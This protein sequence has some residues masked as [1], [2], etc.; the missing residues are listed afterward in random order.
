MDRLNF[1]V[2]CYIRFNKVP[3]MVIICEGYPQVSGRS[4][5]TVGMTSN[6]TPAMNTADW[7][8]RVFALYTEL[9]GLASDSDAG[10]KRAHDHWRRGRDELF[11]SHPASPLTPAAREHFKGLPVADYAPEARLW[12]DVDEE[13]VGEVMDVPTGT[14]GVVRFERLGTVRCGDFG[15]LAL[16][17]HGGYG[18]GLF[19]PVRDGLAGHDGGTYGGGRYLLDTIKGAYLGGNTTNKRLLV[20]FNFAYNPSCAYDEAWACPLPG[21]ANR[22]SAP[23]PFGELT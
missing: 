23:L 13:G 12:A 18:G 6:L 2:R 7:R 1:L 19:L 10:A 21:P 20:D 9:R 5:Y 14:D 8:Q 11:A 3:K 17:R 4:S 16:W 15:S 22:L